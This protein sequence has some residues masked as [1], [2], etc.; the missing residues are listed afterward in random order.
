MASSWG[1]CLGGNSHVVGSVPLCALGKAPTRH[2][3]TEDPA[4]GPAVE[5]LPMVSVLCLL[6]GSG[7][8]LEADSFFT[9]A[10]PLWVWEQRGAASHRGSF[11]SGE[12]LRALRWTS[13]KE[14]LP[15]RPSAAIGGKRSLGFWLS[16]GTAGSQ[17]ESHLWPWVEGPRQPLPPRRP[18]AHPVHCVET[19]VWLESSKSRFLLG[20]L[21]ARKRR[22]SL[23][24]S[25]TA[26]VCL[27]PFLI[28][29]SRARAGLAGSERRDLVLRVDG[30]NPGRRGR[31]LCGT[32]SD[33]IRPR[34]LRLSGASCLSLS[35]CVN[36]GMYH[37]Y[38]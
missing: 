31:A 20:F 24:S 9:A 30:A 34:S 21:E 32:Q 1:P 4:G 36:L 7:V 2:T 29:V 35:F 5:P 13:P 17:P 10:L 37:K 16:R 23:C 19:C 11:L 26:P 28:L 33:L 22:V 27:W 15:C 12:R 18:A 38:S 14:L 6:R 3:A 25:L 8:L